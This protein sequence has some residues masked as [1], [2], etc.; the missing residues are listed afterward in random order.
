MYSRRIGIINSVKSLSEE[1]DGD[2]DEAV[3]RMERRRVEEKL[4]LSKLNELLNT[5]T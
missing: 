1:L 5:Q 4:S 2:T 3:R